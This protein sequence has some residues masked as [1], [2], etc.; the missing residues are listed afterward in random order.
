MGGRFP[1]FLSPDGVVITFDAFVPLRDAVPNPYT[2]REFEDEKIH[3][4]LAHAYSIRNARDIPK[5]HWLKFN[6]E[7]EIIVTTTPEGVPLPE[8]KR[9]KDVEGTK[10]FRTLV[11]ATKYYE[12][13]LASYT[14]SRFD[15]ATGAFV[16][17]EN[18]FT[19]PDPD[20]PTFVESSPM[21]DVMGSW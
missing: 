13:F 6:V 20:K 3:V 16:E 4:R 19:P 21:A 12:Q 18:K 7:V 2:I 11:E 14:A 5:E 15:E 17:A 1:T 8:P 9:V 10:S